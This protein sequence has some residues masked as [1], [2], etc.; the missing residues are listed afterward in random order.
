MAR[1]WWC[2][3]NGSAELYDPT[4]GTWTALAE[5]TGHRL[6]SGTAVGWHRAADCRS[7][8]GPAACTAAALYDPRT[9]SSTTAS[10]M[11]RCRPT[12]PR[13]RSCS[14]ARSSWQVAATATTTVC[15]SRTASAELYVPAGVSLPPLPPS[16]AR[17][18]RLP[19][20]D[21]ESDAAPAR[22]RSRS[23][24]R[25]VLDGHGRQQELRAR[26]AVRGRGRRGRDVTA[27]RVRD[28]ERGPSRRHRAGDLPLPCQATTDGSREPATGRRG[29]V[30]WSA[31]A[32]IGIPGKILIRADGRVGWLSP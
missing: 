27:R 29:R 32:E 25:A 11:L 22:G 26:D 18:R 20:P 30:A 6:S 23:A 1:C 17:P 24:E 10:S 2:R 21:P 13:S 9:G 14:T 31:R 4:T 8:D 3:A 7:D 16:R 5:P 12:A 28:P 19:E 15:V